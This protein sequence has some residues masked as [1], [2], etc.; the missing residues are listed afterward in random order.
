MLWLWC[1]LI[2]VGLIRSLAWELPYAT[3]AALEKKKKRHKL[4]Y[5]QNRNRLTDMENRLVF[6]QGEGE[7]SGMDWEWG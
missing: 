6:T 2:A 1:R 7:G 4:T 3:G 5:L